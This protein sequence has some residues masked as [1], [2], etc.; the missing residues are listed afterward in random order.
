MN[1]VGETHL[2][3]SLSIFGSITAC[4]APR[5]DGGSTKLRAR[6]GGNVGT[7]KSGRRKWMMA[8]SEH[9]CLAKYTTYAVPHRTRAWNRDGKDIAP[10]VKR[11]GSGFARLTT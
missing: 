9:D 5:F 8:A 11:S 4:L 1:V 3:P 10:H 6:S 2:D 7:A